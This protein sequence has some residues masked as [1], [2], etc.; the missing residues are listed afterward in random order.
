MIAASLFVVGLTTSGPAHASPAVNIDKHQ[1]TL[2]GIS[3][4]AQM[5]HQLHIAFPDVF[6]GAGLIAGGPYGCADGSL[7]VAMKR[8]MGKVDDELPI[9]QFA[10]NIRSAA[11]H[12]RVGETGLLADDPVWIFHGRLDRTVAVELSEATVALY[13]EFLPSDN[14]RYVDD[15]EA[16]HNFPTR[17]R[18]GACSSSIESPFIGN[19][20]FD[21]AGELLQHLFGDLQEP[22]EEVRTGLTETTLPGGLA[23]GLNE[24]A[25][26][27]IPPACHSGG[28]ACRAHLVLHGCAQS[29]V[30][31]GTGFIEQS[32]YLPWAAANNIVLAFPQVAPAA[33]NPF[34]CWD[35]WGYTGAAYLWRDGAQM[36]LLSD[37]MRALAN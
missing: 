7:S 27:F 20:D 5:A 33:A 1:I 34:A 12:D 31:V 32:G 26:L 23:A 8:C 35:W 19:C 28:Q 10:E 13:E 4:G 22:E 15:V 30:Q 17:D 18:G 16:A 6:S 37:W 14:I 9:A 24:T 11:Q 21:A 36:K 2:S 25:Y 29:S 3:A